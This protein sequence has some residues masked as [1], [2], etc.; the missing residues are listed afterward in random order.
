VD[1]AGAACGSI[2]RMALGVCTTFPNDAWD[3]YARACLESFARF[4]PCDVQLTVYLDDDAL[5]LQCRHALSPRQGMSDVRIGKSS[6]HDRFLRR[7][8][9]G[10]PADFRYAACRFSHK[11][12]ALKATVDRAALD[13]E[14]HL[15]WL[16]ADAIT[17]APVTRDWLAQFLPTQHA[18][19][20]YLGRP[21]FPFSECGFVGYRMSAEGRAFI[22]AFWAM[23]ESEALF[24]LPQWHDSFVFDRVRERFD[25][26]WFKNIAEGASGVHVWLNTPLAE[27][28]EHWKGA[29]AKQ[30]RRPVTDAEAVAMAQAAAAP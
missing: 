5:S 20:S 24:K 22:D 19:V 9:L 14:S 10:E 27:R 12:A 23:Y 15:L 1:N 4:W 30:L 6:A 18:H 8:S 13:D 29:A 17:T 28:L 3:V 21:H 16:D 25:Q 7:N 2:F 26:A 11:V